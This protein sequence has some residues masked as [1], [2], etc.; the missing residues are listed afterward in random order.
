MKTFKIGE[1]A[2]ATG[3]TTRAIRFYE[4]EGIINPLRSEKGTRIYTQEHVEKLKLVKELRDIGIPV[5]LLKGLAQ[6]RKLSETGDGASKE[7]LSKLYSLKEDIGRKIK[8]MQSLMEEIESL[9]P[10][11]A[12]CKGCNLKPIPGNCYTCEKWKD[13]EKQRLSRLIEE[14]TTPQPH[15]A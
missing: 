8:L 5:E 9:I 6:I 11:V 10:A 14:Q 3:L 4:E 13:I 7:V 12:E 2:K 15:N 1:V